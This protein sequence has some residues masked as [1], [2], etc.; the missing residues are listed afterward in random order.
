MV[1]LFFAKTDK[2]IKKPFFNSTT[3]EGE[4]T[5]VNSGQDQNGT[6]SAYPTEFMEDFSYRRLRFLA[7]KYP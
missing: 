6:Q 7:S 4:D 5:T 2:S 1:F 3:I